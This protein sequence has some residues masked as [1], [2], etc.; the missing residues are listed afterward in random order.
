MLKTISLV[1]FLSAPGLF[2]AATPPG[3]AY[4]VHNLVSDQP[5]AADFTDKNLVNAWGIDTS[6]ASPFWVGDG[7]TG[8]ST[9]YSSNGA[10]SATVVTVPGSAKTTGPSVVTG[11]ITNATGGFPI[12]PTR[13]P[14]FIF[15]TADG[16]VS[17]WAPAVD[18]TH[19]LVMVDNSSTGAVYYGCTPNVRAA[20]TTPLLFVANFHSGAIDVFDT[21]YKPATVPGGFT[22]PSVPAG[23]APFNIFNIG[24][25][26]YVTYAQQNAAKTAWV[27]GAGLGQVA[28]FDNTGTLIK[29]LV[30]G[31]PL[32]AP[33][34]VAIAPANFGAFSGALLVGN[35]GDGA[36][37]AFDATTGNALGTLA[38]P[39]GNP[40]RIPG[41]WALLLGNGGNGGDNQ[42]I[43]FSAG[44]AQQNH[45]LLGS[46]QA[47][48]VVSANA[49]GNAANTQ[50]NGIAPNTYISIYGQNLSPV[51]RNWTNSDFTGGTRLP[52]SLSGV[53]VS[54]NGKAAYVYYVS[55]KQV[56]VLTPVDTAT[57]PVNVVVT[58]NGLVSG[59]A[60][61]TMAAVSP[62]L[63][64][65]KDN[66]S[67]AAIH[68]SGGVVGAA[69]LYPGL[70]SPAK[71]GEII[72]FFATG[73]GATNPA[74]GDGVIPAAPLTLASAPTVSF[75][76]TPGTVTYAGLVAAGVYQ[77]N[78]QVPTVAA[79]DVPVTITAG[80]V[81]SASNTIV[82][83]Q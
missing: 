80:G 68:D 73:L 72:S 62:A 41:L 35:F 58:S 60:S 15:C 49:I 81:T 24:G 52:T 54:V 48:P 65:L 63:F 19:S 18:A 38:D 32:N 23:Y 61:A 29:H 71:A 59:T 66:K 53:S 40:I 77:I 42:A 46:I 10:V 26:I 6:A 55:P 50:T 57:G 83:V 17:G 47:A 11:V 70:S 16:T 67:V 34:G 13:N 20:T 25:K 51:T 2:A 21:N 3:N 31:G 74:F 37:N 14:N 36:I 12:Q 44:G 64:L 79:G 39:Q 30:S 56:D 8:L 45:G 7:G 43:Y 69:T 22:D 78:V 5:G 33:W 27:A 1:L 9:L 4:L 82:T 75:G 76:G 28:V